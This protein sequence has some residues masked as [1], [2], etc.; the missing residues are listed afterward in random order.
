MVLLCTLL[1]LLCVYVYHI[2]CFHVECYY[3][4]EDKSM[5]ISGLESIEEFNDYLLKCGHSGVIV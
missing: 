3:Q 5:K 4:E 1:L 2:Q